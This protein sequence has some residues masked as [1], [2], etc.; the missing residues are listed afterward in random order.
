MVFYN[1][2]ESHLVSLR[3]FGYYSPNQTA[4]SPQIFDNQ[5]FTGYL[6][7]LTRKGY[8]S[9]IL[10]LKNGNIIGYESGGAPS[11]DLGGNENSVDFR[12]DDDLDEWTETVDGSSA[13][14]S[15]FCCNF[16]IKRCCCP[17]A[18][19]GNNGGG[20][21]VSNLFNGIGDIIRTFF[22]GDIPE[23]NP[24][25]IIIDWPS[26]GAP[27][28][29]DMG[30][31]GGAGASNTGGRLSD[32]FNTNIF[33]LQAPNPHLVG[34]VEDFRSTY[35]GSLSTT[36]LFGIINPACF[37]EPESFNECASW[38]MFNWLQS[39]VVLSPQQIALLE[40]DEDLVCE[41]L[42]FFL[43]LANA[44]YSLGEMDDII[45][46]VLTDPEGLMQITDFLDQHSGANPDLLND[47]VYFLLANAIY[48]FGDI[49]DFIE[50]YSPQDEDIS[51]GP[52][53]TG[54]IWV[55]ANPIKQS[56]KNRYA[57]DQEKI[58]K[59]NNFFICRVLAM[60]FEDVVLSSLENFD[61]RN[62]PLPGNSGSGP[63]PDGYHAQSF[64]GAH[65]EW[66]TNG[67]HVITEVKTKFTTPPIFSWS[68]NPS[69]LT[70][71]LNFLNTRQYEGQ[72]PNTLYLVLPAGIEVDQSVV[73]A[74]T[75]RNVRLVVSEV[76]IS[77]L[78][79]DLVRVSNPVSKNEDELNYHP[80][81]MFPW[82]ARKFPTNDLK[83]PISGQFSYRYVDFKAALEARAAL[84]EQTYLQGNASISCPDE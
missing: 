39:Q 1:H 67:Y 59:I 9:N 79:P 55:I 61:T 8:P 82:L 70:E 19:G 66:V 51:G 64:R 32:Y 15:I 24:P 12:C 34:M 78:N 40:A 35:C 76:Q 71:Y 10:Q 27:P 36:Q 63:R 21:F 25:P 6:F 5:N 2:P 4:T 73:E 23:G 41:G 50:E 18:A 83:S 75:N 53:T 38:S 14:N 11:N 42:S 62:S 13:I 43:D 44:G 72:F 17:S 65:S 77:Y 7:S 3:F 22:G 47:L 45:S 60:A 30:G 58:N 84:F 81:L 37:E 48:E 68:S 80:N 28:V 20:G 49:S 52:L 29:G 31:I 46:I 33:N 56:L 57:S 54:E 26:F 69:Q 16:L 74:C